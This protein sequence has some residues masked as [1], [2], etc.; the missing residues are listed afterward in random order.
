MRRLAAEHGDA[1][2]RDPPVRTGLRLEGDGP[3]DRL[4][5]QTW[6]AA[7]EVVGIAGVPAPGA[8][9]NVQRAFTEAKVSL[10]L[11]PTLPAQEAFRILCAAWATDPP[12]GA[13]VRFEPGM[14]ADGWDAPPLPDWLTTTL[15]AAS[16]AHFGRPAG[17]AGEGGSNP[18][19][20]ALGAAFPQASQLALGLFG[21]GTGHHGPDERLDVLTAKRLTA[22]L[23]DVLAARAVRG[24]AV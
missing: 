22:C 9:G 23:A 6:R 21:P 15:G 24:A 11:P 12:A 20:V 13:G 3:L 16:L 2:L 5:R 14:G 10:R 18:F 4:R 1:A 19:L 8:A 17:F 7:L